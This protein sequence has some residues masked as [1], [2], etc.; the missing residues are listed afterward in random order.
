M[1]AS[2]N[3]VVRKSFT[4][5]ANNAAMATLTPAQ[6]AAAQSDA[7][8]ALGAQKVNLEKVMLNVAPGGTLDAS[9]LS[10]L[11]DKANTASPGS[12]NAALKKVATAAELRTD[13][14]DD[15]HTTSSLAAAAN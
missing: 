4:T 14:Q 1:L 13:I 11:V 8:E 7:N 15:L 5:L 9:K 3:D 10:S 12:V 2:S 6:Q